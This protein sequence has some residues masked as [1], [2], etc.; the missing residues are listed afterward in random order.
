[1]LHPVRGEVRHGGATIRGINTRVGYVSQKDT[2]LPWR[3]V[4]QNVALPLQLRKCPSRELQRRVEEALELVALTKFGRHYPHSLSGGMLKRVLF[5]RVLVYRPSTLLLDEPF[6]ALDA[7]QRLILQS[8]L[9]DIWR[10]TGLSIALVTH[11]IDEAVGLADHIAIMSASPG[12]LR[13]VMDV[14]L[15]RPR[16]LVALRGDSKFAELTEA[17]W[18]EMVPAEMRG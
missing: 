7:Q 4:Y 6:A 13:K 2:V 3:T 12:R 9:L 10:R 15:A 1:M 8:E 17:L 5:A 11:D 14:D 18:Q 16:D